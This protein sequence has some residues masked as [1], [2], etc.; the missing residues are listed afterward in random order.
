MGGSLLHSAPGFVIITKVNHRTWA[1]KALRAQVE[2]DPKPNRTR[3]C[4]PS[5]D[6]ADDETNIA[7]FLLDGR[8]SVL[9]TISTVGIFGSSGL[10]DD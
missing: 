1:T 8:I 6:H 4:D 7:A 9:V 10:W 2:E 3:H 5:D